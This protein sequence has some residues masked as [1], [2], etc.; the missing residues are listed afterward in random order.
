MTE[1]SVIFPM[2]IPEHSVRVFTSPTPGSSPAQ[3]CRLS[4]YNVRF[5]H[6]T[7]VN[8]SAVFSGHTPGTADTHSAFF[9]SSGD[10]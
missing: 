8:P 7:A 2:L 4:F 5:P 1:P 9:L 3:L 6:Q 10:I